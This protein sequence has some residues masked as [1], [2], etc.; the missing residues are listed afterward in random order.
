[1]RITDAFALLCKS[2]GKWGLY[3][4]TC[5]PQWKEWDWFGE[6]EKA[7]LLPRDEATILGM[8]GEAII[9]FDG[10]ADCREAFNKIVGDDGPTEANPYMGPMRVFALTCDSE[11]NLRNE[12]T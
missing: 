6:V 4:E 2:T 5:P 7:T 1:M 9:L 12:N 3:L 8:D 10:E 11:G